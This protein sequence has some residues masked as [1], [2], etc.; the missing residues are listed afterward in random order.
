M[1]VMFLVLS[2][3]FNNLSVLLVAETRVPGEN[4]QPTVSHK[5]TLLYNAWAGFELTTLVVIG[6]DSIGSCKSNCQTITSDTAPL[7]FGRAMPYKLKLE[8]R[9]QKVFYFYLNVLI[10][11]LQCVFNKI[12]FLCANIYN[13][14][15]FLDFKVGHDDSDGIWH[16]HWSKYHKVYF[17]RKK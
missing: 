11:K 5:Q 13:S 9:Q 4:L 15:I 14:S 6:T 8:F 16:R 17:L 10:C 7:L 2:A 12:T 1:W 3:T